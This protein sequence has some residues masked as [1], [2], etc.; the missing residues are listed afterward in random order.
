MTLSVEATGVDAVLFDMGGVFVLPAPSATRA[1]LAGLH[2]LSRLDDGA[3]HRAHY[4]AIHH[5]DRDLSDAWERYV[6]HYLAAL[7][8]AASVLDDAVD[9]VLE[10]WT[11]PASER[12][13]WVQPEA[14]VAL[15]ALAEAGMAVGIVSNCD[16]TAEEILAQGGVCQVGDGPATPVVCIVDSEV[17]G[18]AKPDPA[19]FWPALDALGVAAHRTVYVGDSRHYDVGGARAAGLHPVQL[20]PYGM[21]DGDHDRIVSLTVLVDHLL[22]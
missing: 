18:V 10:A 1:P 12:W 13:N 15:G 5:Y 2:D 6:V 7:G 14:A 3:F 19:V 22:G 21:G 16:G 17:V 20:D 11:S 9:A 4:Q 8:L